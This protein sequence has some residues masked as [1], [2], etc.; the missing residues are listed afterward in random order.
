MNAPELVARLQELVESDDERPV[1]VNVD[2]DGPAGAYL[3]A[4]V[5]RYEDAL[6]VAIERRPA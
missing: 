1:V 4:G 3:V 5:E 6:V 2:V